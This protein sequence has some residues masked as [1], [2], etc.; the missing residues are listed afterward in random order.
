MDRNVQT[1]A[2]RK[3][4]PS[5]TKA[6]MGFQI[7]TDDDKSPWNDPGKPADNDNTREI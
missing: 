6:K 2:G 1:D 7:P 4:A 5:D 3:G